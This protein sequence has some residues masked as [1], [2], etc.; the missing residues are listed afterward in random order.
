MQQ[1]SPQSFVEKFI[2]KT[3][4]VHHLC[5]F[6]FYDQL[7]YHTREN[8]IFENITEIPRVRQILFLHH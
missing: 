1:R 2:M 4:Q 6:G 5:N 8:K 7:E 3:L